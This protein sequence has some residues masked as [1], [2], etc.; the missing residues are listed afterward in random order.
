MFVQ[1]KAQFKGGVFDTMPPLRTYSR[2]EK[3]AKQAESFDQVKDKKP[4][5]ATQAEKEEAR[6]GV[7]N[8]FSQT[9]KLNSIHPTSYIPSNK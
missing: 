9:D 5:D 4:T 8:I 6:L 2:R 7:G 1:W 3:H